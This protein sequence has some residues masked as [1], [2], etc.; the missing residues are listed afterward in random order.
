MTCVRR[1]DKTFTLNTS[2]AANVKTVVSRQDGGFKL[3]SSSRMAE[4]SPNPL[5]LVRQT[6]GQHHHYPERFLLFLGNIFSQKNDRA[7]AGTGFKHHLRDCV[8]ASTPPLGALINYAQYADALTPWT[9]GV[10][11]PCHKLR[12]C[13]I[14]ASS[15]EISDTSQA[16]H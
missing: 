4:I 5:E 7:A 13:S 16:L 6:C 14:A 12:S 8:T 2:C 3:E 1:L 9:F 11:T 15:A 10:Q